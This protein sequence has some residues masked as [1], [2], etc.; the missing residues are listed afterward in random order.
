MA[1]VAERAAFLVG[2][3]GS[4]ILFLYRIIPKKESSTYPKSVGGNHSA[5]TW[6]AFRTARKPPR[7]SPNR[8][9]HE[10]L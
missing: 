2:A 3:L 7:Q 10:T 1:M 9:Y 4:L 8:E 5:L 6:L